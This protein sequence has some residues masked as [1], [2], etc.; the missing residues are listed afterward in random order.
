MWITS[1][2]SLCQAGTCSHPD[3]LVAM[4]EELIKSFDITSPSE[5]I[6]YEE[7]KKN[8]VHPPLYRELK[9]TF[10]RNISGIASDGHIRTEIGQG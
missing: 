4:V 10:P 7:T 9:L 2:N 8:F 5:N 3:W 1:G 6:D